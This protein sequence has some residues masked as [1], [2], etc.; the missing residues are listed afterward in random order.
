VSANELADVA[1]KL[2]LFEAQC[3][4]VQAGQASTRPLQRGSVKLVGGRWTWRYREPADAHGVRVRRSRVIGTLADLP[5]ERQARAEAER[6]RSHVLPPL[7]A[8]GASPTFAHVAELYQQAPLT[9]QKPASQRQVRYAIDNH[10]VPAIGAR[11]VHEITP[12]VVQAFVLL[13]AHQGAKRATIA[14]RLGY[15]LRILRWAQSRGF[16]ATLPARGQIQLPRARDAVQTPRDLAYTDGEFA[17]IV[18]GA[19]FPQR[20]LYALLGYTGLRINEALALT[21]RHVDLDAA[22]PVVRVRATVSAGQITAP[23]SPAA[24]RDVPLAAALV[25]TLRE[26]RPASSALTG[27]VFPGRSG[28]PCSDSGLGRDHLTPLLKRLGIK[29]ERLAFHAFRH[30]RAVELA[31]AGTPLVRMLY[32][33]GWSNPASAWPYLMT[34][35]RSVDEFTEPRVTKINAG[36]ARAS[37]RAKKCQLREIALRPNAAGRARVPRAA[38]S[39]NPAPDQRLADENDAE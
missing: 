24:V 21:W 34:S 7:I 27:L 1:A 11:R 8:P 17:A 4:A 16:A 35:R 33:M 26:Y 38:K 28:A 29:R 31:D 37:R 2:K 36:A 10:F 13:E 3:E 30:R 14:T 25:S 22:T 23:K 32:L 15:L 39:A 20:A 12:T 9:L 5:T 19:A 6:L 18:D